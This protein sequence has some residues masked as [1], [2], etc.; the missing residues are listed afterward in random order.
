MNWI[1]K[2]IL[3]AFAFVVGICLVASV[4]LAVYTRH[5]KE[6]VVP[7]FSG[8][9]LDK[10]SSIAVQ[11]GVRLEVYDSAFVHGMAPGAVFSQ[12]P[13]GGSMVKRGRRVLLT[14]N[15]KCARMVS[16][17]SLVGLSMRQARSELNS[18]SLA[19]G[20]LIYV[21][22]M[23]TNN[24]L[25]Q[26]YHNRQIVPGTEIES[27]SQI[28]LVVGL[29]DFDGATYVPDVV[30]LKYLRAV[31]TVQDNSL[32]VGILRFDETVRNYSDS[33]NAVVVKQSP[34]AGGTPRTMGSDV[35]LYLSVKS[36]Q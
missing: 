15:A 1:V 21:E 5:N 6:I 28:D 17:P 22:D 16:M 27:G 34:A 36:D 8:L 23:A 25:R 9:S 24:V 13:S 30:G 29:N 12:N 4:V 14:I 33:L 10:A 35:S 18:R 3:K 19:L 32:N 31:D 7:D 20:R 26:L 2:N 11:A